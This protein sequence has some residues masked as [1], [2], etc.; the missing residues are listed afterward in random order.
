[1]C[2]FYSWDLLD[3][4]QHR[5]TDDLDGARRSNTELRE[6]YPHYEGAPTTTLDGNPSQPSK[7]SFGCAATYPVTTASSL[8]T[9]PGLRNEFWIESTPCRLGL[10]FWRL[11]PRKCPKQPL[12]FCFA[13]LLI[14]LIP[15]HV[16]TPLALDCKWRWTVNHQRKVGKRGKRKKMKRQDKP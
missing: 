7:H 1:M 14:L 4:R 11:A 13:G 15:A 2:V 16:E 6:A 10:R 5:R 3:G 8:A 12:G 9:K